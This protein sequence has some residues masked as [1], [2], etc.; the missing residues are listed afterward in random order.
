MPVLGIETSHRSGGVALVRSG[1]VLAELVVD[2]GMTYSNTLFPSID[3]LLR[4][5]KMSYEDIEAVAVGIG[6]GSFTG[7]RIGIASSKGLS[8]ALGVP[9]IGVP[10]LDAMACDVIPVKS[11]VVLCPMLD[12]K[13][14]QVFTAT[15]HV[16]RAG[17]PRRK[18]PYM[19]IEP[20][21]FVEKIAGLKELHVLFGDGL[22]THKER[23]EACLN[24]HSRVNC[25]L[26]PRLSPYPRPGRIGIL[27]ERGDAG[28]EAIFTIEP[29]YLRPSDAEI[30]RFGLD[31]TVFS[32]E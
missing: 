1:R 10:S 11:E 26:E 5:C 18:G 19:A 20:E 27:G 23:F 24:T 16:S 29:L 25:L 6:P 32:Q 13:K 4:I 8:Y 28:M 31:T 2:V 12:A 9:L 14:G 30:K 17:R 7:L 21:A 3:S 22:A 15:Y